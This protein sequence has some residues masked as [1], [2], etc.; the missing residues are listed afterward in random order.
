[1]RHFLH[2]FRKILQVAP[3]RYSR[4]EAELLEDRILLS[5]MPL[6]DPGL[7][8]DPSASPSLTSMVPNDIQPLVIHQAPLVE[9]ELVTDASLQVD[10]ILRVPDITSRLELVFVNANTPDYQSMLDDLLASSDTGRELEV[11]LLD[12]NRDGIEQI[13][14]IL[15]GY[16]NVDAIHIV[17]HGEQGA[18][19]VGNT[20]LRESSL[21]GRAGE[22]VMWQSSLHSEADLLLYG[23]DL[24]S[25][26]DGRALIDGLSILT[27]TDV[28]ASVDA[29][30]HRDW[31]GNWQLEFHVGFIETDVAFDNAFHE[32]WRGKL[33]SFTVTTFADVVN[34]G[35]GLLSL[36]EAIQQINAGSGGDTIVL[37]RGPTPCH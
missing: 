4:I 36:R 37:A 26:A 29:T 21:A 25:S 30:G 27:G 33:A 17:S 31:G 10:C 34:A 9:G 20:W 1:M 2:H 32:S 13:S 19:Q 15:E 11:Y 7:G 12:S 8:G 5:A 24:A 22:L 23:C 28:A 3:R 35:D 16:S 18:I 6:I 14:A